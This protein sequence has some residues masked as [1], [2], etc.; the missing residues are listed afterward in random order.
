MIVVIGNFHATI[1]NT[2]CGF[3]VDFLGLIY[4]VSRYDL[5]SD[6]SNPLLLK[7]NEGCVLGG[8]PQLNLFECEH[9]VFDT[10]FDT[11]AG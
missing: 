7:K 11:H 8:A 6:F 2:F 3:S 4:D 10:T 5:W 9:D 1:S